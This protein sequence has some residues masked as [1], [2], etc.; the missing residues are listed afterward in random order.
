VGS[1]KACLLGEVRS[2]EFP[3]NTYNYRWQLLE[4]SKCL[5]ILVCS[6]IF[7]VSLCRRT[8]REWVW[9]QREK[10]SAVNQKARLKATQWPS[11]CGLQSLFEGQLPYLSECEHLENGAWGI[12]KRHTPFLLTFL[13]LVHERHTGNIIWLC[14]ETGRWWAEPQPSPNHAGHPF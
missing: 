10:P 6:L 3:S 5:P 1:W 9:R 4:S 8:R 14:L 13:W 7:T 2:T 11:P 12:Y